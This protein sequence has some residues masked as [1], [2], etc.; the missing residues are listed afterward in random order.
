M[1]MQTERDLIS[2]CLALLVDEPVTL[3]AVERK[4][5]KLAQA[6]ALAIGQREVA[7]VRK[8]IL[9]GTDPLGDA[10]SAIRSPQDRRATGAV[11]TPHSLSLIHI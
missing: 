10:F 6:S 11:Y 1:K 7:A 8:A 2:T 4:L 3:S 9:R 5:V